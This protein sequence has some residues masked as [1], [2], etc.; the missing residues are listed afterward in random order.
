MPP[1]ES[2]E[3]V[4]IATPSRFGRVIS[5]P[6]QLRILAD[7]FMQIRLY[8]SGAVAIHIAFVWRILTDSGEILTSSEDVI[9]TPAYTLMSKLLPLR[10]GFL[11]SLSARVRNVVTP[12]G[13]IWV[14]AYVTRQGGS[15]DLMLTPLLQGFPT[16]Q[17]ALVWPGSAFEVA[18]P[19]PAYDMPLSAIA[20]AAG[21]EID[22]AVPVG[23]N[24]QYTCLRFDLTTNAVAGNR[25]I[26]LIMW[27][28]TVGSNPVW[29]WSCP[30]PQAPGRNN[31]Y[32]FAVGTP[33]DYGSIGNAEVTDTLPAEIW[34]GGGN[35]IST[36][37]SGLNAGDQYGAIR[38]HVNERIELPAF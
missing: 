20:P 6:F 33:H 26:N 5:A 31:G 12:P 38:F 7:D 25:G 32:S 24:R 18:A 37:T 19:I 16:V 1:A 4:L 17:Q 14:Q 23:V 21:A 28:G 22:I 2:T 15:E 9:V 10:E 8:Q 27:D 3:R 13:S 30:T 29:V 35:H 11:L 36:I 34:H